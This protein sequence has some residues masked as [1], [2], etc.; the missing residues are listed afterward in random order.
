M[1][2]EFSIDTV[3]LD[4]SFFVNKDDTRS[5]YVIETM[6]NLCK[7]FNIT[8]VAEGIESLDQLS[9]LNK[10]GCDMVQGYVFSKPLPVAKF[11]NWIIE[12]DV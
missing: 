6:V 2:N 5:Q 11:E 1:L 4:R 9:F 8:T 7:K 12:K 10:I 3:K